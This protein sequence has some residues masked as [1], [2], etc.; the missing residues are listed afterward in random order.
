[1]NMKK[2]NY[3]CGVLGLIF[4]AYIFI[5]S[6]AFPT[7][8]VMKIG[9]DFFPR[10]MATGMGIASIALIISTYINGTTMV[11]EAIS[12]KDPGI[13]RAHYS[14]YL[15]YCLCFRNATY[16]GFIP[17]TIIFMM[18]MMYKL[19]LTSYGKY[20]FGICPNCSFSAIGIPRLAGHSASHGLL[21]K[22]PIE[23]GETRTWIYNFI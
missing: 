10:L 19:Q 16:L 23:R 7:D 13:R 20:A 2:I 6:A 8:K 12:F 1:M 22:F 15:C 21:R 9:P 3:L 14:F 5:S 17:S 18:F 4:T 11:A